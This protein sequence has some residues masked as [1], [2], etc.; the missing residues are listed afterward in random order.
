MILNLKDIKFKDIKCINNKYK[1][2]NK[3]IKCSHNSKY[4]GY[5][6]RHRSNYLL[7]ENCNIIKDRFT[8]NCKDY[9]INDLKLYGRNNMKNSEIKKLKKKELFDIISEDIIKGMIEK[10]TDISIDISKIEKIQKFYKK[11]LILK[12][13]DCNNLEDFYTYEP[14]NDIPHIFFYDYTDDKGF[15]WGFDIRSLD[16]LIKNSQFNPYTMETLPENIIN[17]IRKKIDFLHKIKEFK[18]LEN[19]IKKTKKEE[20]NSRLVDICSEIERS[21]RSCSIEWIKGL[22]IHKLKRFYRQLE[23]IWNYRSQLSNESKSRMC[24]DGQIFRTPISEI[25]LMN[26]K[27]SL[28]DILTKDIYKFTQCPLESDRNLGYMYVLIA[29][30]YV[31]R[32]CYNSHID[33]VYPLVT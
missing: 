2:M 6:Y 17:D 10:D 11:R 14:I 23:D 5:C 28:M 8:N 1:N 20:I 16:K 15:K 13:S 31:S 4:G 21:G 12:R 19:D 32:D 29:L 27:I 22:N 18:P 25:Q 30:A 3:C 7:D 26:S 24:P 9:T 33:W